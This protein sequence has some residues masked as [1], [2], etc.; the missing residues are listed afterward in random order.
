MTI[1]IPA[2][3]PTEKMIE[4]LSELKAKTEYR[5]LVVD[6]GSG[7][8]YQALF[9]KAES[10]GATVLHHPKNEGK[11]VALKTG[12][13]HLISKYEQDSVVCAD[14]DGQHHVDDIIK[15]ANAIETGKREMV[16]GARKFEGT[17]PFKSRFGNRVTAFFFKLATGIS[18][19][20][21]QT[22]LRGYPSSLLSWLCSVEGSRFEYELNLLLAAKEAGVAI[23]ELTIATIYENNN[24]GTH[25]RPIHDS[26]LVSM[27][28]LK[29]CSSSLISFLLDFVLL[30]VFQGLTGS[31]FWGVV[32]ARVIS[33]ATNYSINKALVFKAKQVSSM[34]SAPK[35]FALVV[36]IMLLNY[37]LLYFLT[38]V[39]G[40][41]DFLAKLLTEM[42]LFVL[43]YTVQRLFVFKRGKSNTAEKGLI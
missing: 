14:S 3:E 6:D 7:E 32:L 28:I 27:P 23:R 31:L 5:I 35:Y 17:V 22:G 16:L 24:S 4:L 18:I 42:T 33:S 8:R 21:T 12:F 30:F 40:V 41:P 36:V 1:L 38:T 15:I 20:D 34:Q 10:Y 39:I 37:S 29:F 43:S 2:Y 13:A 26:I 11:G 19:S 9:D 25:F